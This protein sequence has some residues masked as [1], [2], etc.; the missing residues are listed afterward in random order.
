MV[1]MADREH[2]AFYFDRKRITR[3]Q[4]HGT[5]RVWFHDACYV[6]MS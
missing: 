5:M 3:I 1:R 2:S 4:L 6:S